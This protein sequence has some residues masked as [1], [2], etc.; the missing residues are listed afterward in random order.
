MSLLDVEIVAFGG[1]EEIIS[2]FRSFKLL[3]TRCDCSK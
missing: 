2:Y 1:N 3:A